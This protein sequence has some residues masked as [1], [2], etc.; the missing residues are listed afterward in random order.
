VVSGKV[1][2]AREGVL[3][4]RFGFGPKRPGTHFSMPS[5]AWLLKTI[6]DAVVR[7]TI[8]AMLAAVAWFGV[9][10]LSRRPVLPAA[11]RP[12]RRVPWEWRTVAFVA[13]TWSLLP[14]IVTS[15]YL[16]IRPALGPKARAVLHAREVKAPSAP[17]TGKTSAVTPNAPKQSHKSDQ[18]R[19]S[20]GSEK[21]PSEFSFTEQLFLVSVINGLLLV[22]VPALLR[23][24]SGAT[25]ADLGLSRAELGQNVAIG[26]IAF[27]LITP[28]VMVV[29]YD[30]Q[31]LFEP[32][33][34]PLERML[35]QETGVWGFVLA[36]ISASIL[37]PLAEELMFRGVL[38]AWLSKIF[39]RK[40][41]DGPAP[42]PGRDVLPGDATTPSG[43]SQVGSTTGLRWIPR[44]PSFLSFGGSGTPSYRALPVVVTSLLFAS[45]H[46]AQM[47][48]PFAIFVLSLVLGL[49]YE[50]TGS[51]V[52][53]LVL[54]SLFNAFNTTIL[55][56]SMLAQ[57]HDATAGPQRGEGSLWP[58]IRSEKTTSQL[59][60]GPRAVKFGASTSSSLARAWSFSLEAAVVPE[61]GCSRRPG[62]EDSGENDQPVGRDIR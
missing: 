41:V 35:R 9:R 3:R 27:L 53:S 1:A 5:A 58:G 11:P 48:T 37:A 43:V 38:Q 52:P 45:A 46:F 55:L 20:K 34:H 13:V 18:S 15:A 29:N 19:A 54:H 28:L 23:I 49:L 33:E 16:S 2:G 6:L 50:H 59:A 39:N 12:P 10:L 17:E 56:V 21:K 32:E 14:L 51:L 8:L 57:P 40:T 60:L 30:A 42:E 47:P 7:L 44:P 22:V 62:D 61:S 24:L 4:W 25:G 36:Y 26:G 31:L